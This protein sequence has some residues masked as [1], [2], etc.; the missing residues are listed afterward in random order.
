M[1]LESSYS[2]KPD[3]ST[4]PDQSALNR[5]ESSQSVKPDRTRPDQ[6]KEHSI[7][8]TWGR[9]DIWSWINW[10]CLEESNPG[11]FITVALIGRSVQEGETLRK[12]AE[13]TQR[14]LL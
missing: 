13:G 1:Y 10:P 2:V 11:K 12:F 4:G 7:G 3:Q 6:N 14:G 9:E 8:L 5:I